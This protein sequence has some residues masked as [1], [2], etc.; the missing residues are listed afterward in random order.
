MQNIQ[1]KVSY[2]QGLVTGLD[3]NTSSKEGKILNEMVQL[4][5]DVSQ[6]LEELRANQ[7]ELESYLET[8]DEDLYDLE[9]EFYGEQDAFFTEDNMVEVQCPQCNDIVCFEA[10]LLEDDDL[11][12]VTCPQ[13]D[14]VVFSTGEQDF[15]IDLVADTEDI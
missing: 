2:L 5:G 13:C 10:D 4:L 6:E 1:A 8:I 15:N 14:M 12:E 3:I 7:S 9:G 11:I